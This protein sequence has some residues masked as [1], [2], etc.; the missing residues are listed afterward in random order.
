MPENDHNDP[1]S[2]T[3]GFLAGIGASLRHHVDERLK[4]PF[5]GAFIV[6]WLA[7]N[8]KLVLI[9]LLSKKSIEERVIDATKNYVDWWNGLLLPI[10]L[11]VAIALGFYLLSAFFLVIFEFYQL[12]QRTIK[13][14]FDL[15]S[16][17]SPK[18]YLDMKRA[19]GEQIESL[20]SLATDNLEQVEVEKKRTSEVADK[21]LKAQEELGEATSTNARLAG[22]KSDLLGEIN[23]LRSRLAIGQEGN[24]S[25]QE[26][27]AI[28]L[29]D[30]A[31]N[32]EV[33]DTIR[34][35]IEV[36]IEALRHTKAP[37]DPSAWN[38]LLNLRNLAQPQ[39]QQSDYRGSRVLSAFRLRVE[40]Y[41]RA[42]FPDL[43][44]DGELLDKLIR[45]IQQSG[46]KEEAQASQF[47]ENV[48]DRTLSASLA[49]AQE[50][51]ELFKS[52]VDYL[53]KGIGFLYP[54]FREVH[55][56]SDQTRAAFQRFG[57]LV[58]P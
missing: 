53:S 45:D 18:K 13:R 50:R 40:T 52:S 33:V 20:R 26:K 17:Q 55:G 47:T 22:E 57:N 41:L 36:V 7:I 12:V 15:V 11:A 23:E 31:R 5:G 58:A 9:L 30:V 38:R 14:R 56:Y 21:L 42:R 19:L 49:Y 43:P 51:P 3:E 32:R 37:T 39:S 16:W 28:A 24:N 27:M 1:S 35:E 2:R 29:S 4:S 48:I 10:L 25:L 54:E 6:S 34:N 46:L 44:I 8:W